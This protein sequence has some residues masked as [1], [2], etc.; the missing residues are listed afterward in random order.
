MIEGFRNLRNK[1]GDN[2]RTVAVSK[3]STN[4]EIMNVTI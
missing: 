3:R 4:E 1:N 2:V